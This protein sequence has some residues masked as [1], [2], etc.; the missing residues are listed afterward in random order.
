MSCLNAF[1]PAFHPKGFVH[2]VSDVLNDSSYLHSSDVVGSLSRLNK[3]GRLLTVK[4]PLSLEGSREGLADCPDLELV[5]FVL[6]GIQNGV[7]LGP[8][9][10]MVDADPW[11]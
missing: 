10:G 3:D 6:E 9:D 11:R 5:Q 8:S 4:H 7:C 2:S 1:A